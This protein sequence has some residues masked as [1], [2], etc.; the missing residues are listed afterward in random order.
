MCRQKYSRAKS[1][2]EE[3]VSADENL[4]LYCKPVRLY[5]ILHMRSLCN[6]S[7]LPRSLKYKIRA[8]GEMQSSVNDKV[9]FN[10]NDC[11]NTL[12]KT[13][14][15]TNCSCP[16]CSMQCGSF[17]GL[18]LHL[19]SS[20]DLFEFDFMLSEGY[21]TVNASVKVDAFAFE[22]EESQEAKFEEFS[23]CKKGRKRSRPRHGRN[24]A[25]PRR[26]NLCFLPLDPLSLAYGT[27]NGIA[28]LSNGN[29]GL[30]YPETTELAGMSSKAPPAI[31][32]SLEPGAGAILATDAAVPP[33]R[34]KKQSAEKSEAR[35]HRLLQQR[36]FYHSHKVQAM[37]LE[38]VLS[39]ED[40][41]DEVDDDVAY[42]ED[43]QMLN[44][45]VDV[46]K[47]EKRF[48]LLW[49]TFVRRQRV[50]A[51]SHVP[52]ACEQFTRVNMEELVGSS[53][54]GCCLRVFLVKLWNHGLV[55]AVTINKC[56]TLHQEQLALRNLPSNNNNNNDNSVDHHDGDYHHSS[57]INNNNN[58][59]HKDVDADYD[60]NNSKGK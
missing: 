14:V 35:S 52:W 13:E 6:P 59:D 22:E 37:S 1:S 32:H 54:L 5:N 39:G 55:D 20:H 44:D 51:D 42:L 46:S 25:S 48:M 19:K 36:Q 47:E 18:Q 58:D 9:V 3:V 60:N 31:D 10:Y 40:S 24:N 16:F 49:N 26:L 34:P 4:L 56:N 38:Q 7:F 41:E 30:G 28:P 17:K 21:Q 23:F 12:Q 53:R 50:V 45:F 15:R 43:Q 2:P 33:S 8:K 29:H 27:E 57:D 11:H